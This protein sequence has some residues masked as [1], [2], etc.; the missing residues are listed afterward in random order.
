[1]NAPITP[2]PGRRR[3]LLAVLTAVYTCAFIDRIII[4]I[5]G[6]AII[7]DLGLTDLQFGLLGGMAFALFYTTFGVPIAW[8][9]ERRSR[10]AIIAVAVA[11]WSAMTMLCGVA[12][13]YGQLLLCRVGVGFGEAGCTPPAHS[14]ISDYYPPGARA[15]ALAI[16]SVGVPLGATIGAVAGGWLAQTFDWRTAFLVVGAPGLVLALLVKFT[17]REP[18]RGQADG[19]ASVPAAASFAVVLRR[20]AGTPTLRHVCAG[21]SLTTLAAHGINLF[22]PAYFVRR[23]GLGLAETGLIFGLVTGAAGATGILLGGFGVDLGARRDVRWYVWASAAG[24]ALAFPFYLAAYAL[25]TVAGSM[26]A[27]LIG[28]TAMSIYFAPSFALVHNL[29]EPR[30]RASMSALL[31]LCMNALGQGVGPV[32]MGFVSDRAAARFFAAGDYAAVCTGGP[33]VALGVEC[34][35]AAT[36][37][38]QWAILLTTVFFLWGAVHFVLAARSIA[39]DHGKAPSQ[40]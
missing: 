33:T 1:M 18:V 17:L 29:V 11:V 28:A 26:T 23:F 19:L 13:T 5:L 7:R 31:L 30:M 39:R 22:A 8:L 34:T 2:A 9:A 15:S 25:G 38:L 40:T 32:M 36:R 14:L 24:V 4:A 6:P 37:G 16:Y 21:C 20:L 27:L 35:T 3:W 12:R 10:T